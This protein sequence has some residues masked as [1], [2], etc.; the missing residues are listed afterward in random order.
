MEK[1]ETFIEFVKYPPDYV[2]K[3][4]RTRKY[5]YNDGIVYIFDTFGDMLKAQYQK[6]LEL[7]KKD[8]AYGSVLMVSKPTDAYT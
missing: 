6:G 8:A 3:Q 2:D 5:S 7:L 4:N 1:D